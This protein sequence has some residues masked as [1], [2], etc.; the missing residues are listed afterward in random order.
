MKNNKTMQAN[1]AKYKLFKEKPEIPMSAYVDQGMA[2]GSFWPAIIATQEPAF[3]PV[4]LKRS[5]SLKRGAG[6]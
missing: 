5:A 2:G 4:I 1:L 6:L 3:K